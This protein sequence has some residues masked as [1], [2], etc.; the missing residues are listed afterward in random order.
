MGYEIMTR[1]LITIHNL[2]LN[3]ITE[4]EM[5]DAEFA[6]YQK[7][8]EINSAKQAEAESKAQAKAAAEGKLAALGLTSND[9]RALGL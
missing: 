9:L 6:N 7:L 8:E 4:R 2:E 1:P 3:E 5:N